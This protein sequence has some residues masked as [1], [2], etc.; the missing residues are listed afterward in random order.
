[1]PEAI[2][3]HLQNKAKITTRSLDEIASQL[4][5]QN[6]PPKLEEDLPR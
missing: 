2:Y 6:L 3:K 5:V 4:F 1:M